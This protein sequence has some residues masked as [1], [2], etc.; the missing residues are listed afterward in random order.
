MGTRW[1]DIL[2]ATTLCL[3]LLV[4]LF[5][6]VHVDNLMQHDHPAH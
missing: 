6:Y 4:P 1:A 5:I 3:C 2:L